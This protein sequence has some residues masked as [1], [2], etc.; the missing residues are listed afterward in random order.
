[1]PFFF[2]LTGGSQGTI[3]AGWGHWG[4]TRFGH[5]HGERLGGRP[6]VTAHNSV[7]SVESGLS[8]GGR[9]APRPGPTMGRTMRR[10]YVAEAR[11]V[12]HDASVRPLSQL[13]LAPTVSASAIK[14]AALFEAMS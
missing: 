11:H 12:A 3:E 1:M 9:G 10:I 6:Q 14:L 4:Q 13:P 7:R 2:D 5:A 8:L